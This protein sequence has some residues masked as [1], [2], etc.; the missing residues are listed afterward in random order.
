MK[1]KNW[2]AAVLISALLLCGCQM[3]TV[4]QMYAPPKRSDDF[5]S[6]QT[7]IQQSMAGLEYSAPTSGENQ[8]IVQTADLDGDEVMECLLFAKGGDNL[9]LH[10]LIFTMVEEEYVHTQTIDLPGSSFDKVEYAP[11]DNKPGM[12]I[13]VGTQVSDQV[14]RS[15]S[16]FS[17]AS[18]E[19]EQL[20]TEDYVS[21]LTVDLDANNK[22]EVFVIRAG[23]HDFDRGIVELFSFQ[24]GIIGR[25]IELNLSE[26]AD[27]LKRILSGN[28]HGGKPAVYVASA[29][30]EDALITDVYAIVDG[31]F[32]NVSLSNDSGTS[33]KTMRNYFVY[34]DDID[35]DGIMEL[36]SLIEMRSIDRTWYGYDQNLIRWYSM[37]AEGEEIDKLYTYHNFIGGWYMQIEEDL[38]DRISVVDLGNVCDFYVWEDGSPVKVM[39]IHTLTGQS[40]EAQS[41]TDN[42]FILYKGESA[43]YAASLDDDAARFRFTQESVLRSFHMIHEHWNT[44]ET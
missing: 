41:G 5:N 36:P 42:R 20:V 25:S 30:D 11:V 23:S 28:L 19:A 16:I 13:V 15:I 6:L 3:R 40:R 12:E 35:S 10:I 44:G 43:I 33:V 18:G 29:V 22:S 17:L 7:V 32:T 38:S 21:F 9:P 31:V 4:D 24:K 2:I 1:R 39:S 37:G 14:S 34:A 27:H 26:P 8:Q